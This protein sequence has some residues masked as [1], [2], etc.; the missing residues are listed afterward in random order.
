MQMLKKAYEG[1]KN[2]LAKAREKVSG[3]AVGGAA[4]ATAAL[5]H[6]GP[7]AAIDT[8]GILADLTTA[9]GDVESIGGGMIGVAVVILVIGLV[10]SLIKRR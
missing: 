4:V 10:I 9:E 7:A 3:L 6:S 8:T 2:L 1:A 5:T